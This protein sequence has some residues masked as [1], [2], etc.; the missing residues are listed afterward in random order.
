[1]P[2]KAL[3]R[4][5]IQLQHG[6][7]HLRVAGQIYS[8]TAR[9]QP[10]ILCLHMI[11]KSGRIFARLLPELAKDRLVIAPDYPGYGESD[12]YPYEQVS[13]QDYASTIY[14]LIEQYKLDQVDLVGYHTGS[15][16]AVELA[17]Q[18]PERVRK[19]I[20]I[21]APIIVEQEIEEFK[22]FFKPIPLDEQGTRYR[23]M[24]ERV[25]HFSGP[26]MT[27]EMAADSMAE[28]LRGGERYED[29]HYA[30][31][32]YA[33]TYAKKLGQIEQPLW[34]MNPADDL[35][36]H[37]KRVDPYLRNATRTDFP[38]WG[39]GF[40]EIWPQQ[41]AAAIHNFLDN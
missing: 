21:S 39:H 7:L 41:V 31:F 11:P 37:T 17:H 5:F 8:G 9:Q 23:V 38:D 24:W 13:I 22:R 40:L 6:Q 16:V 26:G 3:E 20:N 33:A 4:R 2:V 19:L 36:E 27:L 32:D 28:N 10:T 25:R 15:M 30:A 34:V 35:H 18:Y 12:H 29:G 1:M 14:E